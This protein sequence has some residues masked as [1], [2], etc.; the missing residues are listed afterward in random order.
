VFVVYLLVRDLKQNPGLSHALWIPQLWLLIIASRLPSEWSGSIAMASGAAY[1]EGSPLDRNIFLALMVLGAI[2]VTRRSVSW[3]SLTIRNTAIASFFLFTFVSI[4]WSDFPLVAFKR[5]HKVF[6]HV[7]LALVVLTDRQPSHALAALLRRCGF[8][9]LPLSVLYLKYYPELGRGFDSWTGA[10]VNMGITTNKNALGCLCMITGPYFLAMLFAGEK[11]KRPIAGLD[12]YIS[13]GFLYMI[14]WLL[15]MAQSSTALVSTV[16]AVSTILAFRSAM[17]RRH[18]S[19]LLVTGCLIVGLLLALTDLQNTLIAGL[20]EDTTLT[21][22]TDLWADLQRVPINP[23]LGVGFESFWLGP[24][25]NVLWQKYWWHPNQAHNGYFET[26]LNLGWI[27]LLIMVSMI[28]GGY[29][30]ARKQMLAAPPRADADVAFTCALAEFRLAF[31]LALA[32]YNV[33]EATFKAVHPSFFVFFLVSLEYG[34][35]LISAAVPSR[36]AVGER[37]EISAGYSQTIAAAHRWAGPAS[38]RPRTVRSS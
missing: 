37:R 3:G 32:A 12:R 29:R 9:L 1:Q 21:G 34:P 7:I 18:F 24:R 28:V 13:L 19:T 30:T 5:W 22:R 6:G 17:I 31:I 15:I 38:V 23:V 36:T 33:T 16:L 26:Y 20:G 27:G 25:L 35:A 4:L 11:G 10:A 8:I 2:V 14:G